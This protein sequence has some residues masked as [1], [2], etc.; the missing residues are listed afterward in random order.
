MPQDS[1]SLPPRYFQS[2][3]RQ[4]ASGQVSV[5]KSTIDIGPQRPSALIFNRKSFT[6]G[7][8]AVV[9]PRR[10]SSI[11]QT[12]LVSH[13]RVK[14]GYSLPSSKFFKNIE[15]ALRGRTTARP[16]LVLGHCLRRRPLWLA[17]RKCLRGSCTRLEGVFE[18][19]GGI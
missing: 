12:T 9:R 10:A 14:M 7:G 1:P 17:L 5:P 18:A 2:A 4:P 16:P 3:F 13:G 19:P 11:R 15:D 8:L 6:K